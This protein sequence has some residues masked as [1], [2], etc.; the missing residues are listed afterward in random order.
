ME[1]MINIQYP[2]S[3]A[4][5]LRLNKKDFENEMKVSSLVKLYETGKVS[6][7]IAAKVLGIPRVEFLELLSKYNVSILGNYTSEDLQN[8]IANA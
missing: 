5:S 4:N 2:E 3:L 6:S 8:D 1:K 7:G